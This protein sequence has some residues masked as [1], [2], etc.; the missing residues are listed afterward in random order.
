MRF[1]AS[2][3]ILN[4]HT[5]FDS[6]HIILSN[7]P[8]GTNQDDVIQLGKPYGTLTSVT[9]DDS[10][11][12]IPPT[13]RIEYVDSTSAARAVSSLQ[14]KEFR[15]K[16]LVARLDIRPVERGM[17][18][19]LSRKVK[20][21][22]YAPNAIAWAHYPTVATAKS[23]ARRLDGKTFDGQK[24]SAAFQA[25]SLRQ[26]ESFSVEIRG[27]PLDVQPT[28]LGRFCNSSSVTLPSCDR[29]LG[30]ERVRSHLRGLESFEV[31]PTDKAKPK[32][33]AF[34]QFSTGDAAAAAVKDLHNTKVVLKHSPLW[35]E[36]IHSVK[37]IV[38]LRQ[39]TILRASI[40]SFHEAYSDGCQLRYYERDESGAAADPVYVRV[41][42]PRP[43]ALS[44]L[45]A[46]LENLLQGE[47]LMK[48]GKAIWHDHFETMDREEFLQR[49]NSDERTYVKVDHRKRTLRYFGPTQ[50]IARITDEIVTHLSHI[51]ALRRVLVLDHHLLRVLLTGGLKEVQ[52]L[53]GGDKIVLDVV[54]KTLTIRGSSQDEREVRKAIGMLA[55]RRV[56]DGKRNGDAVCPVCYCEATEPTEL[57]CGHIYCTVCL[58][59]LLKSS[60]G[61]S[62]SPLRCICEVDSSDSS[63]VAM[64]GRDIPNS[65][66]R[67]LL[68]STEEIELFQSSFLAY[69]HARP[70]EFRYCP[71]PDCQTVYRP[72]KEGTSLQCTS[73][74]N[75]ICTAC[76]VEYHDGM[77]CEEH[78]DNLKGG[79]DA[80]RRWSEQ[81]GAKPCPKCHIY[82]Q[83]SEGCN[84]MTCI[85]CK[86]HICWVCM[87][88]F[89]DEDAS[90]GVYN[91][92]SK[93]HGGLYSE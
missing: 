32:I 57:L 81:N 31:L 69:I 84:H 20:V 66:I 67:H 24:I 29:D 61:P 30:V 76:H 68:S 46:G 74:L 86:T 12:I 47:L 91:H 10:S 11:T 51:D 18:L 48:D 23:H 13:A 38:P 73:C 35:L 25:P 78:Q 45:K 6:K 64:C 58:R 21:S 53:M 83:K 55:D 89:E 56:S 42:G 92:M 8:K 88:T 40:E 2:A 80:F 85:N 7:L 65:V 77:T 90:G 41:Y 60:I 44:H 39:F 22:W 19:L 16:S 37:Y 72:A 71:T 79:M 59:H 33:T 5:P 34:A 50:D 63:K 52:A 17:G 26:T 75:R 82:I 28:H 93:L 54:R 70:N 36:Q 49:I 1:Q 87:A 43:K 62:F 9:L 27:L 15:S 3:K 4:V 14:G